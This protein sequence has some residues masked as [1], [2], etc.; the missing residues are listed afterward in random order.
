MHARICESGYLVQ[1]EKGEDLVEAL[2]DFATSHRITCASVQGIGAI[3]DISLGFFNCETKT[4]D[5]KVFEGEYEL[6]NAL[7][8]ISLV[9]DKPFVHLHAQISGSDYKVF[10]GH[11]FSGKIAVTGEFFVYPKTLVINRK[12][13]PEIGL[14]LW[15]LSQ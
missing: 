14:K 8:N 4:Y 1:L 11:L 6:L 13:V 15:D 5:E 9:D 3:E 2:T 10:G 7:G 12:E